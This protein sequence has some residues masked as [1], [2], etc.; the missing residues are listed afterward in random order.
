MADKVKRICMDIFR[1]L[2][3]SRVVNIM[4]GLQIPGILEMC[5]LYD[6]P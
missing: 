1:K 4:E 5:Y 6:L 2:Q 3:N